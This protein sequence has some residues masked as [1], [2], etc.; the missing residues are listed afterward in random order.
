MFIFQW[1][2]SWDT[3]NISSRD[4]QPLL[5]KGVY[6]IM[7]KTKAIKTGL[8]LGALVLA[9]VATLINSKLSSDEMK[10]AVAK[11]VKEVTTK[12]VKGS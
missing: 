6:S 8:K 5:W 3:S 12:Q 11:E 10:E 4:S 2:Q 1:S 7:Y 9:G